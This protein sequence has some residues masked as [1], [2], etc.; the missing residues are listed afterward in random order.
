MQEKIPI[1]KLLQQHSK[2]KYVQQTKGIALK[3]NFIKAGT[4]IVIVCTTLLMCKNQL[5]IEKKLSQERDRTPQIAIERNPRILSSNRTYAIGSLESKRIRAITDPVNPRPSQLVW[6]D[7]LAKTVSSYLAAV[8]KSAKNTALTKFTAV[9]SIVYEGVL[10]TYPGYEKSK[11]STDMVPGLLAVALCAKLTNDT[12]CTVSA[13]QGLR[14][15]ATTY[16]PTGN[17]INENL[18]IPWIQAYDLLRPRLLQLLNATDIYMFDQFLKQFIIKG[19]AYPANI[20]FKTWRLCIRALA[21]VTLADPALIASTKTLI[22]NHVVYNLYSTGSSY[23]YVIRDALFYHVYNLNAWLHVAVQAPVTLFPQ[24]MALIEAAVWFL[25]P[26]YTREKVH[27]EFLNSTFSFDRMRRDNNITTYKNDPWNPDAGTATISK[28]GVAYPSVYTWASPPYL[29]WASYSVTKLL[30]AAWATYYKQKP[31][32]FTSLIGQYTSS[33]A[34]TTPPVSRAVTSSSSRTAAATS[35]RLAFTTTVQP[36]L[37][38]SSSALSAAST[39][40]ALLFT[41]SVRPTVSSSVQPATSDPQ[42]PLTTSS[43]PSASTTKAADSTSG[44]PVSSTTQPV[45]S[46]SSQP[47]ASSTMS[48]VQVQDS[49]VGQPFTSGTEAAAA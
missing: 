35:S 41:S 21:S 37:L 31:L 36:K 32:A 13:I 22:A 15:W 12:N 4:I 16:K 30:Q 19:D 3:Y 49:T 46:T 47:F 17:P 20:N 39:T 29:P 8:V 9:A 2:D 28:A 40:I 24:G 5:S 1:N 14:V 27:I 7:L 45:V 25:K 48:A 10:P 38:T 6:G 34:S 18:L 23:D 43:Q 33:R 26:F 42:V 11:A 44:P